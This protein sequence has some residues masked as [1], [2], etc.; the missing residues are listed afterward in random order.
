MRDAP[1]PAPQPALSPDPKT[2]VLAE[3][4]A[5]AIC[6]S[7]NWERLRRSIRRI[8]RAP[9]LFNPDRLASLSLQEF[10]DWFADGLPT[11]GSLP[12]RHRLFT[13]TAAWVARGVPARLSELSEGSVW[14]GGRDGLYERL[15]LIPAF[16]SDPETKKA[17]VLVQE[18]CRTGLIEPLDPASVKPAVEY[19]LIRLYLRTE[20]VLPARPE[21]QSRLLQPTTFRAPLISRV[22][23][24]VENAMYFTASAAEL[25]MSRLNQLEWEIARSYCVRTNARCEGPHESSKPCDQ[26]VLALSDEGRCPFAHVCA[27]NGERD[28]LSRVVEPQLSSRYDFY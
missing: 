28:W 24:A 22:R 23:R 20:R 17:R 7:T 15:S 26:T 4:L 10:R 14:L 2:A 1:A 5:A 9:E 11:D 6:H 16:N 21:D 25:S 8:A 27:A 12:S 13:E 18:L 19:H 3:I